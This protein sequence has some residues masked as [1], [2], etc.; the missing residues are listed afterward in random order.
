VDFVGNYFVVRERCH[1]TNGK[2]FELLVFLLNPFF[3]HPVDFGGNYFVV[4]ERHHLANGK[5]FRTLRFLFFEFLHV[6][7]FLN[8]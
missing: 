5:F 6:C 1:P 7:H 2:I 8:F 3:N 4:R